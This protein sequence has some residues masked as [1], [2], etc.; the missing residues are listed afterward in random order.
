MFTLRCTQKLLKKFR[1]DGQLKSNSPTTTLGDWYANILYSRQGH[2]II[3][4]S[5]NSLLPIILSAK[6][7]DRFVPKFIGR[8]REILILLD[9]QAILVETE[10]EQMNPFYYGRTKNRVTLG[11]LSDYMK[12]LK[13]MLK[14]D[15]AKSELDWSLYF[16]ETP[17]G[18]LK[19]RTSIEVTKELFIG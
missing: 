9:I 2:F 19:Y 14:L 13:Y 17:C 3:C 11:T 5:E 12:D 15:T 8:I 18:P 7:L 10:I 6:D 1:I 4:I 16:A